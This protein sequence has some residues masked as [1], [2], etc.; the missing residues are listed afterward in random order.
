MD[1]HQVYPRE[2]LQIHFKFYPRMKRIIL[3]KFK[4]KD[5]NSLEEIIT[6]RRS[7]RE[8]DN[9]KPISK[10]ELSRLLYYSNYLKKPDGDSMTSRRSYPSAG[11]RYPIE[12]YIVIFNGMDIAN[13][14][15]HYNVYEHTLELLQEGSLKEFF[16][17]IC[18]STWIQNASFLIVLSATPE[19]TTI[20]YH[21]RG[22]RYILFEVGHIAQDIML[23]AESANLKTCAIGGFDD[24]RLSKL[25]RCD[26]IQEYPLYII[27]VGK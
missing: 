10:R 3:D 18:N 14:L 27:A 5:K 13:G 22:L 20:K 16:T 24:T 2:W 26:K 23:L 21:Y 17:N 12:Q 15:Y 6:K 19:R 8:F 1:L 4:S 9:K 7:F 11:A 25:L